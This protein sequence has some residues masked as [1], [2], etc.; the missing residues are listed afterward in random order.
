MKDV[1]LV[2]TSCGRFDLL[3]KTL[4]SFFKFNKHPIAEIIITEDS[5]EGEKLK[6]L[7][8]KYGNKNF[9]LIINKGRGWVS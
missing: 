5:T 6:K 4:D 8:K 3:E 9:N 7:I 1:T 2:I